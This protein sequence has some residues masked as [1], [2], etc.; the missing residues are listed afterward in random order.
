MQRLQAQEALQKKQAQQLA[1]GCQSLL[2]ISLFALLMEGLLFLQYIQLPGLLGWSIVF[3]GT[4]Y[5]FMG[6]RA[7]GIPLN[8]SDPTHTPSVQ[9]ALLFI[10]SLGFLTAMAPLIVLH[11][12]T[13]QQLYII[14]MVLLVLSACSI[15][16]LGVY[17]PAVAAF[18][19][20]AIVPFCV[21]F[22]Q[23][24]PSLSTVW[25][26]SWLL[27]AGVIL[28][29]GWQHSRK[30][31]KGL[32]TRMEAQIKLNALMGSEKAA[33][34]SADELTAAIKQGELV[35]YYQPRVSGKNNQV[36]AIEALVRWQHPTKGLLNPGEFIPVAEQCHLIDDIGKLVLSQACQEVAKLHRQRI[37]VRLSVNFS[38]AQLVLSDFAQ[39]VI[40]ALENSGLKGQHLELELTESLLLN[41]IAENTATLNQL[42]AQGITISMDDFGTGYSSFRYLKHFP[43]DVIKIDQSFVSGLKEEK[44]ED[45]AII[46]AMTSLAQQLNLKVVAEGVETP[47][48][49]TLLKQFQCDEM[50]GNLISPPVSGDKLINTIESI[51]RLAQ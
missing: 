49:L 36:V 47:E 8:S 15:A 27:T 14:P 20:S 35:V 3:L 37:K 31:N 28:W 1:S 13:V 7:S 29:A 46:T 17:F 16:F 41:N 40:N 9:N 48:T 19:L 5:Y 2:S 32:K 23:T 4:Q 39:V 34:F 26:A 45:A 11:I 18:T 44:G 33:G 12:V 6:K 51:N 22:L 42:K 38:A 25:P 50:Q 43:V 24:N 21:V 10:A 30:I